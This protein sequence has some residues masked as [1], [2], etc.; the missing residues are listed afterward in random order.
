MSRARL[1][2]LFGLASLT[3][4]CGLLLAS[5]LPVVLVPWAPLVALKR[6]SQAI[7]HMIGVT[8][9]LEV[10]QGQGA[11]HAIPHMTCFR[12]TGQGATDLILFDNLERCRTGRVDGI[13]DPFEVF[14]LKSLTGP[15]VDLN[16]G[17]RRSL[18]EESMQPLFLLSD[19]YCHVPE[20]ER[21]KVRWIDI[22]AD[23]IGL[24]LDDGSKGRVSMGGRRNCAR[25]TWEIR[26]P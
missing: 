1:L 17:Y 20:A 22:Q 5:S 26:R 4:Y 10:F 9:G 2:R 14:Q 18:V 8:P 19:Y 23:Y 25:P 3:F 24:S 6:T 12:V 11:G 21:A 7:L 16:L 13:R 15:L